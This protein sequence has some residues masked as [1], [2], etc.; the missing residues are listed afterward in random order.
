MSP[1]ADRLPPLDLL[2]ATL[3]VTLWGFNFVAVKLALGAFPPFFLTA[4]RFAV[5]AL[6][7]APFFRPRRDQWRGLAGVAVV[8]GIGHFG[9]LFLGMNGAGA[10]T[11]AV[12]IQLGAPFSV[13]LSWL[14]MGDSPGRKRVIGMAVAFAG[15]ALLAGE[16]SLPSPL[17]LLAVVASAACWASANILIKRMGPIA[18]M[19]LNGGMALIAAPL[20]LAVS[21]LVETGQVEGLQSAGWLP[22]SAVAFTAVG[23]TVV[24]YGLWYRLLSRHP[25]S[26]VVP[27][28]L[29]G[30]AIGFFAGIV[31]LGEPASA[32]KVVGGLL[33]V[34]GVAAIELGPRPVA[35]PA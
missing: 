35:P 33:T 18:P 22:W 31:L 25:L 29:L 27:F 6:L 3:V 4:L 9:L 13:L 24:A 14:L 20:L 5:V 26:R 28:T 15:V 8:L 1:A 10:S 23:S 17:P 16:P 7:L 19:T 2:A 11:T 30:P 32:L 12:A 21:A 34:A